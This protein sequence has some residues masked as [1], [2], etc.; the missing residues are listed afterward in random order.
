MKQRNTIVVSCPDY[1][2]EKVRAA[3]LAALDQINGLSWLRAGMVVA[4][5]ANLIM[6]KRPN[7]AATTHPTMLAELAKILIEHGAKVVVGDSPGGIYT[8]GYLKAVYKECGL[9]EVERTGALLN[10]NCS[11]TEISFP[12]AV[13]AKHFTYTAWLQEADAVITF[14]KMKTHGMMGMSGAV[15]NQFGVIPGTIKPE[16]HFLYPKTD[17]FANML[18]DLNEYVQPK[19]SL[20]DGVVGMEGNGPTAG[21]PRQA[22]VLIASHSPYE[23]DLCM[24]ALMGVAPDQ[25]PT[26]LMSMRRCLVSDHFDDQELNEEIKRMQIHKYKTIPTKGNIWGARQGIW[27]LVGTALDRKP[28]LTSRTKCIAC[29]KCAVVCPAHAITFQKRPKFNYQKC[30]RCFCCQEFCP[31]SALQVHR[32]WIAK[33]LN[34]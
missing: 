34:R 29:G 4:I 6:A 9:A 15:K 14:A 12:E 25:A 19:L 17:D 27:K 2:P 20:I 11:Q 32:S 26:L 30:I 5:K 24:A 1:C 31:A 21:T 22:G 28:E 13:V 8:P 23:A 16:Y 33:L 18:I 3:L 7:A 10:F